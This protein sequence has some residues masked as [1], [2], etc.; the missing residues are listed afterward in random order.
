[1]SGLCGVTLSAASL[2]GPPGPPRALGPR[3]GPWLHSCTEASVGVS[4]PLPSAA[5]VDTATFHFVTLQRGQEA[6]LVRPALAA[7]ENA[8]HLHPTEWGPGLGRGSV[9][10]QVPSDQPPRPR[11]ERGAASGPDHGP[12]PAALLCR[13]EGLLWG[14]ALAGPGR[15]GSSL[16]EPTWLPVLDEAQRGRGPDLG[17][18]SQTQA[19]CPE[20][21][22]CPGPGCWTREQRGGETSPDSW[23]LSQPQRGW[24]GARSWAAL[25]ARRAGYRSP[26][27]Y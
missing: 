3:L 9:S 25:R 23:Q 6:G 4:P 10:R 7:P 18:H 13:P 17:P 19:R 11:A 27:S 26:V 21:Y 24:D 20:R 5:C 2:G 16:I 1:M 22:R 12:S 8:R 14:E 15:R